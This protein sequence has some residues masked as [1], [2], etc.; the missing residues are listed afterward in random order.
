MKRELTI[1]I[2][3]TYRLWESD[4]LGFEEC[5]KNNEDWELA[6]IELFNVELDE[7]LNGSTWAV[8]WDDVEQQ[9]E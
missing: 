7:N 1:T 3:K 5:I 8:T 4:E 6:C 2:T 9:H